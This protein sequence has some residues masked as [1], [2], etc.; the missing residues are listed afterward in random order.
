MTTTLTPVAEIPTFACIIRATWERGAAQIDAIREI[1]RRGCWLS[2]D[3]MRQAGITKAEYNLICGRQKFAA[4]H[5]G[6]TWSV[7]REPWTGFRD[8]ISGFASRDAAAAWAAANGY[9][10]RDDA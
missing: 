1:D 4:L 10:I 2:D 6:R 3:Q 9:T 5:K 7:M 8:M